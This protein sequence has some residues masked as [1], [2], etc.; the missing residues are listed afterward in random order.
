MTPQCFRKSAKRIYFLS[1]IAAGA[2]LISF[3]SVTKAEDM[4]T[5]RKGMW[6]FKR[7]VDNA[8][9]PGKPQTT[10]TK[11]CTN[12]S[13]DMKKQ[14][15]TLSKGGC[16]FSPVSKSGNN[17]SFSTE[18]TVQGVAGQSKSLLTVENDSAYSVRVETRMGTQATKEV[19]L[20]RR[21]GDCEE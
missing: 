6:E 15:E 19:L 7:T 17:Y 4:P 9:R 5:F 3:T 20:A 16:K 8:G 14:R 1:F 10:E 11:K 2:Y 12:P 13:L 18:C 21:T